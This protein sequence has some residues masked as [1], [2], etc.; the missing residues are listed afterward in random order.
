M[1]S[2][3]FLSFHY[4]CTGP[5]AAQRG[6][7]RPLLS[8]LSKVIWADQKQDFSGC[9]ISEDWKVLLLIQTQDNSPLLCDSFYSDRLITENR[10]TTCAGTLLAMDLKEYQNIITASEWANIHPQHL[11]GDG[12]DEW[13]TATT[14]LIEADQADTW[15][16]E[17]I[18][19]LSKLWYETPSP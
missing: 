17:N 1:H 11:I 12:V 5:A 14:P 19:G 3:S 16:V 2:Q 10:N 4:I 7:L 9:R 13:L 8:D 15:A 18:Y 6:G